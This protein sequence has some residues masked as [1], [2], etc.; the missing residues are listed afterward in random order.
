M[1]VKNTLEIIPV[2][3]I[4][5]SLYLIA[6]K[7]QLSVATEVPR[8]SFDHYFGFNEHWLWIYLSSYLSIPFLYVFYFYKIKKFFIKSFLS[9]T[10]VS[11]I[12]FMLYPTYVARTDFD[13]SNL[14]WIYQFAFNIL[15]T[16]DSP[17]NCIPSLHVSTATLVACLFLYMRNYTYFAFASVYSLLVSLSTLYVKQHVIIDV[18]TGALCALIVFIFVYYM[19][20]RY[21]KKELG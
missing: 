17:T 5:A 7:F 19:E 15:H 20:N 21:G 8:L 6:N 2:I 10:V 4:Y 12:I 9:L 14:S 13:L 11:F 16:A 18:L 1:I 3:L